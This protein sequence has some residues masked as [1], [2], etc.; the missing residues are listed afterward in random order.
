[1]SQN[2]IHEIKTPL[3]NIHNYLSRE[4]NNSKPSNDLLIVKK[5][6]DKLRNDMTNFLD[7]EK[8]SKG[9]LF[10]DHD[11]TTD[12]S[13]SIKEKIISFK[14]T[15]RLKGIRIESE[16]HDD[17]MIK[18]DPNAFDRIINNLLNNAIR[19]NIENGNIMIQLKKENANAILSIADTG[20][21]IS[22]KQ[23]PN[24]FN[25]YYQTSHSKKNLQGIGIGLS[26]VKAIIDDINGSI[27]VDSTPGKG[28][29]FTMILPAA[30]K[31]KKVKENDILYKHEPSDNPYVMPDI[32]FMEEEY[33]DE[34]YTIFIAEDNTETL[35]FLQQSLYDRYNVFIASDG[36][37]AL[38]KLETIPK[39]HIIISDI[40]MDQM[41]GYELYDKISSMEMFRAVPFIFLTAKTRPEDKILGLSKGAVHYISK[42][43]D[44]KEVINIIE[45]LLKLLQKITTEEKETIKRKVKAGIVHL[46]EKKESLSVSENLSNREQEVS[47]LIL[48]GYQNKEIASL[49]DISTRTVDKHIENIYRKFAVQNRVELVTKLKSLFIDKMIDRL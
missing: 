38:K 15:A 27:S 40:M 25:P 9:L 20:I 4:I 24:L 8:L 30:V 33:K 42:P 21:G 28:S 1:M 10:Y 39:P 35:S 12:A 11:N 16:I 36:R 34:R 22:E 37:S 43:F 5:N 7:M 26:I 13:L 49:L 32:K 3:T 18:I 23:L 14:E 46:N 47:V 48:N 6:M 29:I 2:F 45:S 44:I 19:Y 41:D 17:I 31:M